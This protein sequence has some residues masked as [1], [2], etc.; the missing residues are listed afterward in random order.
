MGNPLSDAA[1][2]NGL[3]GMTGSMP[4]LEQLANSRGLLPHNLLFGFSSAWL[5]TSGGA[6]VGL[7]NATDQGATGSTG[8]CALVASVPFVCEDGIGTDPAQFGAIIIT[9]LSGNA[10]GDY[11][12]IAMPA[13]ADQEIDT[14]TVT[15]YDS[16]PA[17]KDNVVFL[18]LAIGTRKPLQLSAGGTI[19]NP[20][21]ALQKKL[22]VLG[23]S[24]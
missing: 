18:A 14:F 15:W 1:L 19:Y 2:L 21:T 4:T 5:G 23:G 9:P 6:S 3:I 11:Y 22:A 24:Q 13:T 20:L 16:V 17:A 7:W 10:T 8:E 12:Q